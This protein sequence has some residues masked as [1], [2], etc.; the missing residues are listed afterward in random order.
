MGLGVY[1]VFI[2]VL[3]LVRVRGLCGRF[4]FLG[5]FGG[6]ARRVIGK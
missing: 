2:R 4:G 5:F 6:W 1:R 3:W